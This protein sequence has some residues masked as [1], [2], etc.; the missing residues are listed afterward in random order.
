MKRYTF[1]LFCVLFSEPS[2]ALSIKSNPRGVKASLDALSSV[3]LGS[4]IAFAGYSIGS[5]LSG[6]YPPAILS[7]I[8]KSPV[9]YGT[10]LILLT[11]A[12]GAG[13][14]ANYESAFCNTLMKKWSLFH[15]RNEVDDSDQ[16]AECRNA[17][18]SFSWLACMHQNAAM[19]ALPYNFKEDNDKFTLQL[20]TH[21][22]KLYKLF[23]LKNGEYS[24]IE[25]FMTELELENN[26]TY[27]IRLDDKYTILTIDPQGNYHQC[28]FS[29]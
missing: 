8:N 23:L 26:S 7:D 19:Q 2:W 22:E 28:L 3:F 11:F 13:A 21:E 24:L 14:P 6:N 15:A 18:D 20:T 16:E 25:Q 12:L 9:K 5:G 29:R 10:F 27:A 4:S 1:T 17:P